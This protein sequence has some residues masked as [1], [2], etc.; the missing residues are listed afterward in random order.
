[1]QMY[2]ECFYKT[3]DQTLTINSKLRSSNYWIDHLQNV[4][5]KMIQNK[6]KKKNQDNQ[7][8]KCGV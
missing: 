1:M 6:L 4:K 7:I 8:S 2:L 5:E 3:F